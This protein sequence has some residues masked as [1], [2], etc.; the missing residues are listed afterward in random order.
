MALRI[1][2]MTS[3]RTAQREAANPHETALDQIPND[4][5]W[6]KYLPTYGRVTVPSTVPCR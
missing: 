4:L 5:Q 2:E 1:S 6:K 3:P